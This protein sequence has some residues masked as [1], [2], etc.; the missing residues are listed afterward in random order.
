MRKACDEKAAV[1]ATTPTTTTTTSHKK[2]ILP[3]GA[4]DLIASWQ[5]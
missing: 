4:L 1:L 5:H 3:E 2:L